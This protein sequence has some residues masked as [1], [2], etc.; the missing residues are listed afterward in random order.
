MSSG[1]GQIPVEQ[2]AGGVAGIAA[3]VD[4]LG[5]WQVLFAGSPPEP[6]LVP[7]GTSF[8]YVKVAP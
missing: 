8:L 3:A 6:V 1:D 4:A 7:D 5:R 2:I